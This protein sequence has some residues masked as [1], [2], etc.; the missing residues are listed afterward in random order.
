M[1]GEEVLSLLVFVLVTGWAV[2][3][4]LGAHVV[5]VA[6]KLVCIV[7]CQALNRRLLKAA[8]QFRLPN[9]RRM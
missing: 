9:V 7:V 5:A 1:D 3:G 4:G 6:S 2:D 8:V